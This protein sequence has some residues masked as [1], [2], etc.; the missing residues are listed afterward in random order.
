MSTDTQQPQE[1]T[2][3]KVSLGEKIFDWMTYG[4]IA[5][6]GT[7]L[8]TIPITY[9]AKYGKGAAHFHKTAQNL[10]KMGMSATSADQ[11]VMTTAL[12]QGGNL[13]LFPVKWAED[14]KVAIVK[15]IN[16]TLGEKTDIAA[17][18]AEDRQTW[19]SIIKARMVAWLAVFTS[20]KASAAV[21][22][23]DK[24]AAFE[25]SFARSV[26]CKPFGKA[27]HVNGAETKAFRYGKIAALD[28]FATAAASALLYAGSRFFA[29]Y[30][31]VKKDIGHSHDEPPAPA[32]AEE[33]QTPKVMTRDH[34]ERLSGIKPRGSF[35]EAI[36]QSAQAPSYALG[37]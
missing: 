33:T 7:F 9:W 32:Q 4:G 36:S 28:L 6:V 20:F 18:E 22:G 1:K 30:G 13:A 5:G 11:A 12:M 8:I 27:T 16:D 3:S 25:E 15:T 26:V 21:I 14:N 19:G 31:E 34:S 37:V 29:H 35:T 17:L 2:G 24:F 23:G 10:E